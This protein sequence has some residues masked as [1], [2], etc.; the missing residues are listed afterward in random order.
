MCTYI[1]GLRTRFYFYCAQVL[2]GWYIHN[3]VQLV[4]TSVRWYIHTFGTG[5]TYIRYRWYIHSYVPSWLYCPCLL[6]CS[7][8]RLW[9]PYWVC[10]SIVVPPS[11]TMGIQV[12]QYTVALRLVR[13]LSFAQ[14]NF[15]SH[16]LATRRQRDT[17]RD[18]EVAEREWERKSR[19]R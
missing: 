15:R 13:V 18:D 5:G 6:F 17:V 8:P 12:S 19:R 3:L 14:Q 10:F 16:A 4:H 11:R 2:L 9:A 7:R 1:K